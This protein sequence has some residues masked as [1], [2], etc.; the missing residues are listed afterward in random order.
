MRRH[1]KVEGAVPAAAT[2]K[3]KHSWIRAVLPVALLAVG[4]PEAAR[5]QP[6]EA[7]PDTGE[8]EIADRIVAVVD[9]DP[10][11]ASDLD[12]A[13]G[14]G[15]IA[16][17][18]GESER[19][20]RR[21]VL[22]LLLEERLRAHEVDRFGFTEISLTAVEEAVED[23]KADFAGERAFENRLAELGLT[24]D[25]VRQIVARQIMVI[26]YVDERLGP[27]IFV[28]LDDIRAYYESVLAPEMERAGQALP[29]LTAVQ[30]EIRRVL[31][32]Q[33]LNEEIERWTAELRLE[34]DIED[35]FD[36]VEEEDGAVSTAANPSPDP[37]P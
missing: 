36:P 29:E 34:A 28:S 10:I 9:E 14:L 7:S 25:D 37:G 5:S 26:T 33:R 2:P 6:L 21:R 18:P 27:R 20:F 3:T 17:E 13:I 23:L 30:E 11:L 31:R 4:L 8:A 19:D 16:R 35:Y 32:E 22:D 24:D 1:S 12:R 15:L